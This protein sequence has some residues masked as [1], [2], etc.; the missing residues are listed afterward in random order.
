MAL[1]LSLYDKEDKVLETHDCVLS[2]GGWIGIPSDE[3]KTIELIER[4]FRSNADSSVLLHT[5]KGD[6]E[7][8]IEMELGAMFVSKA[9]RRRYGI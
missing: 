4:I 9:M 8:H 3:H 6:I 7:P 2:D 5:P 1:T